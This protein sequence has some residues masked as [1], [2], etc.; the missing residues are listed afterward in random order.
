VGDDV[1]VSWTTNSAGY[2]LENTLN[3]GGAWATNSQTPIV[4]GSNYVVTITNAQG[5]QF[6]RL[7]H[8]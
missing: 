4:S 5:N 8:P 1:Q 7:Y 6:F 3:L 2:L